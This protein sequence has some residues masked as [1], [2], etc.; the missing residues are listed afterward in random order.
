MAQKE[1]KERVANHQNEINLSPK[2]SLT[3]QQDVMDYKWKLMLVW[4]QCMVPS[5][6]VS[7]VGLELLIKLLTKNIKGRILVGIVYFYFY[8]HYNYF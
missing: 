1:T 3:A 6:V 2:E 4:T 7:E 5:L 8:E